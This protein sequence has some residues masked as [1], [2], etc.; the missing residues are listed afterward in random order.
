MNGALMAYYAPLATVVATLCFLLLLALSYLAATRQLDAIRRGQEILSDVT[1]LI[2]HLIR[3]IGVLRTSGA[4]ARAFA[5]W[6][7]D[8]AEMRARAYRS[9]RIDVAARDVSSPASTS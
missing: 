1:T 3:G 9:Q 4:E 6:G 8:F 5:R 2:F 7:H